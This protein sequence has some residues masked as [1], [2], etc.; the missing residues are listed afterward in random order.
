MLVEQALLYR[1]HTFS[2][3]GLDRFFI[4]LTRLG[5]PRVLTFLFALTAL[6]LFFFK[7]RSEAITAASMGITSWILTKFL[8]HIFTRMR[9]HLWVW[10]DPSYGYSFPSGHTLGSAV[11]YGWLAW[12]LGQTY[13]R[14]KT[15]FYGIAFLLVGLIGFS[16]IYLGVHWP[17]DVL[18]GWIGGI[19][20]LAG[21]NFSLQRW[22][23]I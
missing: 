16:R 21:G 7:L 2:S 13:P 11:F 12:F 17:S 6:C 5:D 9:P 10:S 1:L 3:P 18:G 23:K 4:A 19:L 22:Q 14:H 20:I 15:K 8:K